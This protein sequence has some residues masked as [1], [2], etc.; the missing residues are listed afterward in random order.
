MTTW[1]RR[2]RFL[3]TDT[4]ILFDNVPIP[5]DVGLRLYWEDGALGGATGGDAE[6]RCA[7]GKP[8]GGRSA[9]APGASVKR[10]ESGIELTA[11]AFKEMSGAQGLILSGDIIQVVCPALQVEKT[12]DSVHLY[13]A[14]LRESSPYS[15][16]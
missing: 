1:G 2:G 14:P 8:A 7:H 16:S 3:L 5:S 10:D 11:A 6:N 12:I 15:F 9:P 13:R 4:L